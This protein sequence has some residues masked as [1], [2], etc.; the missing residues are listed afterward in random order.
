MLVNTDELVKVA[1]AARL[2]GVE[3]QTVY[4]YLKEGRMRAFHVDGQKY[5]HLDDIKE[6]EVP[7]PGRN[8]P[9]KKS[10]RQWTKAMTRRRAEEWND[11]VERGE[12]CDAES[13]VDKDLI[14]MF[15]RRVGWTYEQLCDAWDRHFEEN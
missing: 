8:T 9:D 5:V 12:F 13:R 11:A 7:P 4:R 2:L 14:Q 10:S 15:E 6:F 1:K 3:R